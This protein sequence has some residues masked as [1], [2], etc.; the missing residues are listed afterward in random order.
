MEAITKKKFNDIKM[1]YNEYNRLSPEVINILSFSYQKL[2]VKQ[3]ILKVSFFLF[4]GEINSLSSTSAPA[5]P[6]LGQV[7]AVLKIIY[8]NQSISEELCNSINLTE[9]N[10]S[11]TA[12]SQSY[13]YL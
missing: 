9:S 4:S 11:R 12:S 5:T 10:R 1:T 13:F 8:F 6:A 7:T 3:R 2:T